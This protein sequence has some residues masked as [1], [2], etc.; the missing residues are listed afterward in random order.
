MQWYNRKIGEYLDLN[1]VICCDLPELL[2]RVEK[3]FKLLNKVW[4]QKKY[5]D[6]GKILFRRVATIFHYTNYTI[7]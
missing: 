1:V 3:E 7:Y 6:D 2:S 4:L 5:R